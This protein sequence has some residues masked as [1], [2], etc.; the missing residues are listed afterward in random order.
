M[1]EVWVRR[2][3]TTAV[4]T[5]EPRMN[6]DLHGSGREEIRDSNVRATTRF[7]K[8]ERDCQNNSLT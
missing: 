8:S 1:D 6:A 4:R 5:I 7:S 3:R 2:V